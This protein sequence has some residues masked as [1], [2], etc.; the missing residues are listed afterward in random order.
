MFAIVFKPEAL[1]KI[2]RLK[3]YH[4]V[5]ILDAIEVHL[6]AEPEK[7]SRGSIKRLRGK[8]QTTFRLRVQDY[9]VFYDVIEDRV[10]IIQILHKSETEDFYK[11]EGK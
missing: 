8:Q 6:R 10:E 7:T 4:A 3:R 9:R 2:K 11:E 1:R 5:A